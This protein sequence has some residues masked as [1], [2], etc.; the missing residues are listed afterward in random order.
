MISDEVRFLAGSA[1]LETAV[2]D[3]LRTRLMTPDLYAVFVRGFK[4]EWNAEQKGCSVEQDRRR[5][6]V[7]R[8]T[9]RIG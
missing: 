2:L 3:A 6:E 8:L 4:A 7:R 5:D 1:V 9:S